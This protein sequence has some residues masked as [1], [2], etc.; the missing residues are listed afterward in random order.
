[1]T[2]SNPTEPEKVI[3]AAEDAQVLIKSE[4]DCDESVEKKKGSNGFL[5]CFAR[6]LI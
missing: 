3:D 5:V 2:A 4:K 6:E 1:M